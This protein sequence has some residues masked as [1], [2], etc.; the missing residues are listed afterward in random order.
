MRQYCL[1]LI[2][3]EAG[4]SVLHKIGV[5]GNVRQ[6]TTC[7]K[8]YGFPADISVVFESRMFRPEVA[9]TAETRIHRKYGGLRIGTTEWFALDP[10]DVDDVVAEMKS[11]A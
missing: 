8:R 10:A 1:Y 7:I 4:Q 9:F 5:S 3:G 2:R 6:R 11:V